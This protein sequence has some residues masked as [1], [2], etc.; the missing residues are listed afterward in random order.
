MGVIGNIDKKYQSLTNYKLRKY[1]DECY[2]LICYLIQM[3]NINKYK[4]EIKNL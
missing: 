2:S 4:E 3:E 1:Y